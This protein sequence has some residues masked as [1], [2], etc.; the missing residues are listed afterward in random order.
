MNS[1][2][3]EHAI[4]LLSKS[5]E[6]EVEETAPM[7]SR[8]Q[9]HRTRDYTYAPLVYLA[10]GGILVALIIFG[11]SALLHFVRAAPPLPTP[12]TCLVLHAEHYAAKV[13]LHDAG[14]LESAGMGDVL[15]R[16]GWS[17]LLAANSGCAYA[18]RPFHSGHGYDPPVLLNLTSTPVLPPGQVCH[19]ERNASAACEDAV[20]QDGCVI[21]LVTDNS[22]RQPWTSLAC[23]AAK[24]SL[25][26]D[27]RALYP[28]PPPSSEPGL[29]VAVHYRWGDLSTHED[30]PR[31]L[32]LEQIWD[33][34]ALL[35]T[36]FEGTDSSLLLTLYAEG[37]PLSQKPDL[38]ISYTLENGGNDRL[39]S[40]VNA[41]AAADVL[42]ASTSGFT[43][44]PAILSR[45]LI[46]T[47]EG[48]KRQMGP[49]NEQVVLLADGNVVE[50]AREARGRR[51][52]SAE[53]WRRGRQ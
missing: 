10:G 5:D 41:L 24:Q 20:V 7:W 36:S 12:V 47:N 39:P 25:A 40:I 35:T 42:V 30:D 17:R 48:G 2:D 27:W 9:S 18:M 6:Q 15:R 52:V 33:L 4:P 29:L 31:R 19:A 45:G 26:A 21:T 32:T 23:P 53:K 46:V 22:Y 14:Q 1:V 13:P 44:L 49:F 8:A 3:E 34:I 16:T 37:L 38:G 50:R 51:L 28:P 43:V 11:A